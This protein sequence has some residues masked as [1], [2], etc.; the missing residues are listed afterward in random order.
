MG[1][2][3]RARDINLSRVVAIKVLPSAFMKNPGRLVRFER[4]ARILASL[5]HPH[6]ATIHDFGHT[7]NLPYL[8]MELIEGETLAERVSRGPLPVH[9]VLEIGRQIA[10]AL[11]AAHD[12]G[13]VHQDIKPAN[14]K[15]LADGTVKVL[16]FGLATWV[17]APEDRVSPDSPT[18]LI[19]LTEG[20]ILIG[21]APYISPE[22]L[23]NRATDRRADI[24]SFGC[25]LFEMLSGRSAFG[26]ETV[27]LTLTRVLD[28]DPD[29][30]AISSAPALLQ[31][32][33]R[34]CLK[35]DVRHRIQH[36]GDARIQI[37]EIIAEPS[38][39]EM[40]H[41]KRPAGRLRLLLLFVLVTAAFAL[42]AVVNSYFRGSPAQQRLMKSSLNF[43]QAASSHFAVS[44]DGSRL[45]FSMSSGNTTSLWLRSLD[46]LESRSLEGTEGAQW[47]F[48]S[49]DG[50]SFA[51]FAAGKLKRFD[52]AGGAVRTLANAD[53]DARGGTWGSQ[54]V[55]IFTTDAASGLSQ[56]KADGGAVTPATEVDS[57][58]DEN[59]H[60]WPYFLPD[61]NR[62]L[63]LARSRQAENSGIYIGSL[64]SR[65]RTR[66]LNTLSN[67]V[68]AGGAILFGRES[69]LLAQRFDLRS[70]QLRGDPT[71][72]AD[73]VAYGVATARTHFS[74][75]DDGT[76]IYLP[77]GSGADQLAWFDR[78]GR[79][80]GT[81][82]PANLDRS[83][84]ASITGD[85]SRVAAAFLDPAI[86][87]ADIWVLDLLH[88]SSTRLTFNPAYDE[89]P[90]WSPDG[91]SVVFASHRGNSRGIYLKNLSS[92]NDEQQILSSELKIVPTDW[93]PDGNFV[94]LEK[95]TVR[96]KSDLWVMPVSTPDKAYSFLA[97]DFLEAQG[98]FSPDGHS[99]AY[100]SDESGELEV[101]LRQFPSSGGKMK[102]STKGGQA[103]RWRRDGKELFYLSGDKKL[104]SV[105]MNAARQPGIPQPLFETNVQIDPVLV[106]IF[107]Y[108]PSADG[109]RFL[110]AVPTASSEPSSLSVVINWTLQ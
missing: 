16:D 3:Y 96:S 2:V 80:Q 81:V 108:V 22:Q 99:L 29:W 28:G 79:K 20:P 9:D 57:A 68:Y 63:Y 31:R 89:S 78:T 71:P 54:D 53:P 66:L 64:E 100:T 30:G 72:I 88:A 13:I 45:L 109:K 10:L 11:E 67:A 15:L 56:V 82:G 32:L 50:R 95:N 90:V 43:T 25:V 70:G 110:I 55:I 47:P 60:R 41:V 36:I 73:G 87:S 94:M 76:M 44:R 85:Q 5:N 65:V 58:R 1:E 102:V 49:P 39:P 83:S 33:I 14:I 84:P 34:Q 37:E 86:G 51:F 61:G 103:P 52:L 24:W 59:S 26:E 27:S 104:M 19:A 38:A 23:R 62:F 107:P 17:Q 12:R 4:E 6:I 42:G 48:W 75:A 101:Y 98:Q 97:S 8:V 74:A 46:S 69:T 92:A 93:S 106:T 18:T 91:R 40:Q 77:G 21:T 7:N 105:A 35:R